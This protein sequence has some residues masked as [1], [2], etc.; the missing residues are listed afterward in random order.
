MIKMIVASSNLTDKDEQLRELDHTIDTLETNGLH[1]LREAKWFLEN[2]DRFYQ[3]GGKETPQY[4][5]FQSALKG[6]IAAINELMSY[7]DTLE[8]GWRE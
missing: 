4:K 6:A 8:Q 5:E 3:K 7:A 1:A 2:P